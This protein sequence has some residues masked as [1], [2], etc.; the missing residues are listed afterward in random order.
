MRK[1]FLNLF[2]NSLFYR[3]RLNIAF[4]PVD[5]VNDASM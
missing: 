4:D 5:I 3:H 2:F 1:V